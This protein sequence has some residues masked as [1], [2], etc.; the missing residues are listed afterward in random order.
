MLSETQT[1]TLE[2]QALFAPQ[3]D[4]NSTIV[5][6]SSLPI[7]NYREPFHTS[8]FPQIFILGAMLIIAWSLVIILI[9]TTRSSYAIGSGGFLGGRGIIGGTAGSST[10]IGVGGRPWLQKVA[11]LTVGISLMIATINTFRVVEDQYAA[12]YQDAYAVTVEVAG[13]LEL[14]IIRVISSTFLWLAQVQ[15]LIRL[16]PRH[17]EKVIIKWTGFGLIFLDTLFSILNNF[18]ALGQDPLIAIHPR[19]ITEAIPALAYL[20]ELALSLLYAASVTYYSMVKRRFAYFHTKMRSIFFVATISITSIFIPV[21]FFVM[22][23]AKP[24]LAGWGDYVRWAGA[25]AASV[26]VWEWVERIEALERDERK[27]GILG[28]EVFDG[29]EMLETGSS[30]DLPWAGSGSGHQRPK[31]GSGDDIEKDASTPVNFLHRVK[32]AKLPQRRNWPARGSSGAV[33]SSAVASSAPASLPTLPNDR[34]QPVSSPFSRSDSN[35]A[36]STVYAIIHHPASTSTTPA[37]ET[38]LRS[39]PSGVSFHQTAVPSSSPNPRPTPRSSTFE[40]A[41]PSNA[42]ASNIAHPR[43]SLLHNMPNPFKRRRRSPPP[44]ISNAAID[45]D[46]GPATVQAHAQCRRGARAILRLRRHHQLPVSE[47]PVVVVPAQLRGRV[48]SPQVSETSG[49]GGDGSGDASAGTSCSS[50]ADHPPPSP[51]DN[52]RHTP[53][54]SATRASPQSNS[55][56]SLGAEN[57]LTTVQESEEER[58]G[59]RYEDGAGPGPEVPL[60]EAGSTARGT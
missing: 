37:Q 7:D 46:G 14:R 26:V 38:A 47:L 25:A 2:Q 34:P 24:N 35:S 51:S 40:A 53:S 60:N 29:D 28:R 16:F 36:A 48:W 54:P 3:C 45:P 31:G 20:F 50:P 39:I 22:D 55:T 18:V 15:T 52:S 49:G 27:D 10:I 56:Q 58:V 13:S 59:V 57:A 6:N 41:P 42:I 43:P 32:A 4:P 44:E 21:I 30:I 17:K 1:I 9:I 5:S 8:T 12:G 33:R 11:A 19:K 23:I